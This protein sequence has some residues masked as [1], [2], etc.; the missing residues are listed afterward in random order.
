MAD[1]TVPKQVNIRIGSA[2]TL[3]V[4]KPIWRGFPN[5]SCKRRPRAPDGAL[6]YERDGLPS[7]EFG[8]RG[9]TEC[10]A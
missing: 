8:E 3:S 7:P 1:T 6:K 10:A 4:P 2:A 9:Q 5:S